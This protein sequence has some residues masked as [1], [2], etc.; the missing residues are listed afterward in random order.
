MV[1]DLTFEDNDDLSGSASTRN[2]WKSLNALTSIQ[3][4]QREYRQVAPTAYHTPV[5]I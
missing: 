4:Y 1:V 2:I 3:T 5:E